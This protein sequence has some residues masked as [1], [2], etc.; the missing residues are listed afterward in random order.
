[1]IEDGHFFGP[2]PVEEVAESGSQD[3]CC[4]RT[5]DDCG[6]DLEKV[7]FGILPPGGKFILCGLIF[8]IGGV[9]YALDR[10][11]FFRLGVNDVVGRPVEEIVWLN[12]S[13][14]APGLVPKFASEGDGLVTG[15]RQCCSE[16]QGLN[17][18]GKD[19]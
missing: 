14:L 18:Q 15:I 5:S 16:G 1:V 3:G 17:F 9:P 19:T 4:R 7:M 11:W 2:E 13:P 10:A 6:T 8:V 12:L